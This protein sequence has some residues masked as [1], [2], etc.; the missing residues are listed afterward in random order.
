VVEITTMSASI[1]V[2]IRIVADSSYDSHSSDVMVV[3]S[4]HDRLTGQGRWQ[5]QQI[6]AVVA[7][8]RN[9]AGSGIRCDRDDGLGL[10]GR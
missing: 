3:A 10:E 9:P 2:A 6:G 7:A 5:W 8:R 1:A 4:S